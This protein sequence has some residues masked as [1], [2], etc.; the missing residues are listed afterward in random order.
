[1]INQYGRVVFNGDN[2]AAAWVKEAKKRGLP[3]ISNT[4]DAIKS[5]MSLESEQL[6]EKYG[7]LSKTELHSRGEIYLEQYSK[8]ANIE[9]QTAINMVKKQY[10]P[11]VM[12]YAA[13]LADNVET[14]KSIG[15][16]PK[17][18]KEILL[19]ITK[20][21]GEASVNLAALEAATS[22]AQGLEDVEKAAV[23]YRD[24]VVPAQNALRVDIDA[25][26]ELVPGDIWPVPS[27]ADMLFNL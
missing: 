16:S 3:N 26:E 23:A 15:V 20:H 21:L 8:K 9:A 11:V 24:K 2:Y 5:M 4:V 12:A 1:L 25:L 6:F 22:K 14:F 13:E 19:K 27:Y 17:V 7:V 10:L 18:Q